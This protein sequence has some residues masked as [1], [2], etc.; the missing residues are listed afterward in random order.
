MKSN[1]FLFLAIF[2]TAF[3]SCQNSTQK[4][5]VAT[6]FTHRY[7]FDLSEKEWVKRGQDGKITETKNGQTI[8]SSYKKGILNGPLTITYKNSKIIKELHEYADGIL[9]KKVLYNRKALPLS[10][11]L[12]NKNEKT[13]TFWNSEGIPLR[14]EKYIDNK[15]TSAKYFN[16]KNEIESTIENGSGCRIKKDRDNLLLLKENFENFELL[17]RT[18]FHSNGKVQ[19]KTFFSNYK[20]NGPQE[21]FSPSGKLLTKCT[22]TDGKL[23]GLKEC[24]RSNKK[25]LE[26]PYISGKKHGVEKEYDLNDNLVKEIHWE[27]GL[28]HGSSRY[29]SED[30]TKIEWY[31]KGEK[32]D[33]KKFQALEFREKLINEIKNKVVEK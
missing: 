26:I 29:Y 20:L 12:I 16:E 25:Y 10:E 15:L 28:K 33:L 21:I 1:I 24:F 9:S 27:N 17:D 3:F 4:E 19:S 11:V 5:E 32:M 6:R 13:I 8:T 2:S 7:G 22:W 14:I 31:F 30:F 23:D 18:T